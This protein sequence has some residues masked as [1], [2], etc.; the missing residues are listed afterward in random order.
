MKLLALFPA[1][2]LSCN[3]AEEYARNSANLDGSTPFHGGLGGLD[4][5][6]SSGGAPLTLL[7]Q[8]A[9]DAS[10]ACLDGSPYGF[11]F[12][13][14]KTNSTKWT[15]SIEG[16]GWCYNEADCYARSK[17][18]LGSSA[19]WAPTAGCG[20]MNVKDGAQAGDA[21]PL[22]GDCNCLYMPYGDG[23]SFS[24]YRPDRWP[25]PPW[26]G[27]NGTQQLTFRGIKN[28]DATVA[29]A[30]KLGLADATDF[31]L[32][33]GSAGG[34][35]AFLHMDRVG[36]ALKA[37]APAA[38]VRGAPVVGFFLDHANYAR[39]NESYTNRMKYIYGMQNLTFG[40]DGG[41]TEACSKAFPAADE[42]FYC[43]M[44]PH[45]Q[46]VVRTPFFVF[47]SKFDAWQLG[48]ELQ[49]KWTDDAERAAVVQYGADFDAQ[50]APVAAEAHGN[51]AM[52]TTCICHGCPWGTL[53]VPGSELNSYQHYAAWT[54]GNDTGKDAFHIDG[55][56][57][58]GD[59]AIKDTHC[60][61]FP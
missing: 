9:G 16:G 13:P 39:T 33:G 40:G 34:L 21:N 47:N 36:A 45:M 20:C 50:F 51:G 2:A 23:A 43:F 15:I 27:G 24:G 32:T 6:L 17:T 22:D 7:P 31:V 59:G 52:I 55:R 14:S 26:L 53:T 57:P 12:S 42:Q 46:S 54:V 29:A 56:G 28:F 61:K 1:A 18:H 5:P 11:Y 35:S 25:V 58:N 4:L 60:A 10:P 48:N 3:T 37:A 30:L 49:T 38:A 8:D 19:E 41:L 44:S